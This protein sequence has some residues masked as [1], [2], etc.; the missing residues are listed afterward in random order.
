MNRLFCIVFVGVLS[1]LALEIGAKTNLKIVSFNVRYDSGTDGENNWDNRKENLVGYINR[2]KA[3]VVCLQEVLYRQQ[4]FIAQAMPGY[5]D[6]GIGTYDGG[7]GGESEPIFYNK[8]KFKL[9]DFGHFWLSETPNIVGSLG[10]GD[11]HPHMVTWVKLK[12]NNGKLFYVLNTH[13]DWSSSNVRQKSAQLVMRWIKDNINDEPFIVA[14]DFNSYPESDTYK[15]MSCYDIAK[16]SYTA[17]S[18]RKGVCY[19]FHDFGRIPEEKRKILDYIFVRNDIKVKKVEIVK[20]QVRNGC[21]LSD[22]NP[23]IANISF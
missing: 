11:K 9:V 13:F 4:V 19:S 20:E 6:V 2:I 16:D 3:D 5:G 1:A 15:T 14:G 21:F 22:H 10:W 8:K 7:K 12:A 23:L 18:K 17:A